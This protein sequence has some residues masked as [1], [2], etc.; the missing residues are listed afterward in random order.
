VPPAARTA[1]PAP[2][3]P[4]L[5]SRAPP[6]LSPTT[7]PMRSA[8]GAVSAG[9]SWTTLCTAALLLHADAQQQR[10]PTQEAASAPA[11]YGGCVCGRA[12]RRTSSLC[13]Q[14]VLA[15]PLQS[16]LLKLLAHLYDALLAPTSVAAICV[17]P[18]PD[19]PSTPMLAAYARA[20][21]CPRKSPMQNAP[22]VVG[23]GAGRGLPALQPAWVPLSRGACH[24]AGG[25][26]G[27]GASDCLAGQE[28]PPDRSLCCTHPCSRLP[29]WSRGP[30]FYRHLH[31]LPGRHRQP[32]AWRHV[33]HHM[34]RPQSRQPSRHRVWWVLGMA[35]CTAACVGATRQGCLSHSR[36][37]Q[38]RRWRR[39]QCTGAEQ[40]LMMGR[41][42]APT[43][44]RAA[45]CAAEC[46]AGTTCTAPQCLAGK[47][48]LAGGTSCTDCP[49]GTVNPTPG[50]TCSTTCTAPK[51][52]NQARTECGGCWAW[53]PALQ[54]A[55]VP[56]SR[57][58]CH[59]AGGGSGVAGAA[60]SVRGRSSA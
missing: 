4:R 31:G 50:G 6:A 26:S 42:T 53:L 30:A 21:A 57:G 16:A 43:P 7:S 55:W 19:T 10:C 14:W 59:T 54:P 46:P 56:L 28:P 24:T 3:T 37:H 38:Q 51:V 20:I 60:I 34:H 44:L 47:E 49:A 25:S 27:G 29:C 36:Q 32:H 11:A 33:Q 2:S 52:A 9:C 40:R 18:A 17:P 8:R 58:A 48:L 15:P 5:A 13:A 35:A 39:H 45:P 22:P 23:A 1:G 12:S 41:C